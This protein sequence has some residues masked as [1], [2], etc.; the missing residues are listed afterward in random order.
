MTKFARS[1]EL[2]VSQC[3]IKSEDQISKFFLNSAIHL[4]FACLREAASAKAGILKFEIFLLPG[5]A[6]HFSPHIG[7]ARSFVREDSL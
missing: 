4:T 2:K 7:L 3:Q 1:D 5:I 6:Q